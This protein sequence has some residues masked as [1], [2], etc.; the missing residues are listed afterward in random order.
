VTGGR[1]TD[2]GGRINDV[3]ALKIST[4]YT[5]CRVLSESVASLPVRL[6]R[7]TPQGRVQE[8]EDPLHYLLSV[9]PNP[10]MTSFVYFGTV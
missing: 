7:V 6:L 9:A 1:E 8:L 3:T 10:E 2:S 5:C 4:V